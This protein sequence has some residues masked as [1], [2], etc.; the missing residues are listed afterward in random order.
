VEARCQTQV[1]QC[2]IC[3]RQSEPAVVFLQVR[4][5]SP[6]C[7]PWASSLRLLSMG[8]TVDTAPWEQLSNMHFGFYFAVLYTTAATPTTARNTLT[9]RTNGAHTPTI[10]WRQRMSRVAVRMN[11]YRLS[12]GHLG[13]KR[14]L[15]RPRCSWEDYINP[16]KTE[17]NMFYVRTQCVPRCKHSPLRL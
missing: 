12:V 16:L 17:R 5:L 3:G 11:T 14:Q 15:R 13:G 10:R 4:F 8:T 1:I 7:S 2:G 9:Y 6:Y